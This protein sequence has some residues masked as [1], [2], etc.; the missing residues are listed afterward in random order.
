MATPPGIHEM[1]VEPYGG[2]FYLRRAGSGVWHSGDVPSDGYERH[3][4]SNGVF[5]MVGTVRMYGTT[6]L[7]V[8]VLA[9]APDLLAGDDWQHVVEESLEA[10]GDLEVF[11]W[12]GEEPVATVPVPDQPVRIRVSWA[13]L[14]EE[15]VF[16]GLDED[17]NSDE[18]LLLQLWPQEVDGPRVLRCWPPLDL[19]EPT[20]RSADGRRQIEGLESV[21]AQWDHL[22]LVSRLSHPYSRLPGSTQDHSSINAIYRDGRDG[23]IWADGYDIRRTLREITHE[24]AAELQR[25]NNQPDRS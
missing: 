6:P 5:V 2:Q 19:P 21:L 9:S 22:E 14:V 3:L 4:W 17:G 12:D 10:G 16:D 20:D 11:D 1:H 8:E 7:Q 13:G 18:R 25:Q 23:T 24:E 15:N